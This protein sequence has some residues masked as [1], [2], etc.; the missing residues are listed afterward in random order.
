ME[1]PAT[2][3]PMVALVSSAASVALVVIRP[4][5]GQ[6][7]VVVDL[8]DLVVGPAVVVDGKVDPLGGGMPKN[9]S[10]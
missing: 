6:A 9:A 1:D 8:V 10:K 2:V 5:S 3:G 7:V 4:V